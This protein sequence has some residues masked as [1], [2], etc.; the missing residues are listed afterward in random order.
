VYEKED[1]SG[2]QFK[3]AAIPPMKG[4]ISSFVSWQETQ[5]NKLGIEVQYNIDVSADFMKANLADKIIIATGGTPIIPNIKG[6]TLPHVHTAIDVLSGKVNV[7]SK[8]VVIGGGKTGA[9]TAHH[10]AMQNKKVTLVEMQRGIAQD[11]PFHPRQQ[12]LNHLQKRNV[13]I[14]T[15][16]TVTE[17]GEKSVTV[18]GKTEMEIAADTVVLAIGTK[19]ENKLADELK[20]AGFEVAVIGDAL[21]IGTVMEAIA[22]GLEII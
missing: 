12:L 11:A 14:M 5:L 17:I 9:E 20:N 7:G 8:I 22:Q 18:S 4:E 16:T 19:S 2:G 13:N 21:S 3:I 1:R 10:L 6:A 15:N